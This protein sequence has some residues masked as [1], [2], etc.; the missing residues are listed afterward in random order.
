[1]CADVGK[2]EKVSVIMKDD[3]KKKD[4]VFFWVFFR[5]APCNSA[6]EK[7]FINKVHYYFYNHRHYHYYYLHF[8]NSQVSMATMQAG[9]Q[10]TMWERAR[11]VPSTQTQ[12]P[13]NRPGAETGREGF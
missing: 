1:M 9:Q 5:L 10:I 12:T 4:H 13:R 11:S 2:C 7:C 8:S 6:L 3:E